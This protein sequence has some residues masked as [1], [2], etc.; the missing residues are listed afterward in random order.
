[1]INVSVA[2]VF[3]AAAV[4][5]IVIVN[6]KMRQQALMEA[7]AKMQLMLDHNMAVHA[8]FSHILKPN[9]FEWTEPFRD[10][11]VFDPS[12]M[13]STYAV[14]EMGKYFTASS[15]DDYYYKDATINARNP[16]N[17]A[18]ADERAF[19]E[20]L[21]ANPGLAARSAVRTLDG[22]PYLV[23]IQPGETMEA[24]CLRCHSDPADAPRDLVT[25]YGPERSFHRESELGTIVSAISVRVPLSVAYAEADR[26][27]LQLSL[28]LLG[29]MAVVF[30][31]QFYLSR[32]WVFQPLE[33]IR[34]LALRI[35]G[36][37]AHLGREIAVPFG[38]ELGEL[39]T[40]FNTMSV[41]LRRVQERLV[42]Q[43][44][45]A[46]LGQLTGSIGHELRTP[47]GN[48]KNA[49]Y[50]LG[51]LL[52]ERTPDPEMNEALD[53]IRGGL[54][55]AEK[56]INNLL[57]FARTRTPMLEETS[58][59]TI[60]QQAL[61]KVN[62]PTH[63]DLDLSVEEVPHLVADPDQLTQVFANLITNAIQAMPH[64]G[65]LSICAQADDVDRPTRIIVSVSDTGVGIPAETMKRLFEPMFTTKARGIGLGLA[66]SGMLIEA[67]NGHIEVAS[68]PGEGT[69]FTVCLPIRQTDEEDR[70]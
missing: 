67:H 17:E 32:R 52:K 15:T 3:V 51:M 30:A 33:R 64:G 12:W 69:T 46:V 66:L 57:S 25:L 58:V 29:L 53:F 6:Q 63:I 27:S 19:L 41:E 24:S 9:L 45:L 55:D 49:A 59:D 10:A 60:L 28:L 22:K 48:I 8:Y 68:E 40:A 38:R 23:V 31:A 37:P 18:D 4:L 56:V 62:V 1:M 39:T 35:S 50:L 16:E 21:K 42:Q 2:I 7:E 61:S 34:D 13:S 20:E 54:V 44:R 47:L 26:L 36:D 5:T 14:R 43:E 70:T 11:D 65:R